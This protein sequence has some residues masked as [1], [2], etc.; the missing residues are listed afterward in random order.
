MLKPTLR[1]AIIGIG[2]GLAL[3]FVAAWLSGFTADIC[4]TDQVSHEHCISHNLA[5]FMLIQV[6]EAANAL[7]V[8]ITALATIAIASFTWTLWRSTYKLWLA[9]ERQIAISRQSAYAAETAASAAKKTA[10]TQIGAERAWFL[11]VIDEENFEKVLDSRINADGWPAVIRNPNPQVRFHFENFGKSPA[12]V[13]EICTDIKVL[14]NLPSKLTYTPNIPWNEEIVV[15]GGG[16][17]PDGKD[18]QGE[19]LLFRHILSGAVSLDAAN[20]VNNGDSYFWF[21]GRVVYDDIWGNEHV[22]RFCWGHDGRLSWFLP[23][24]G[25]QYNE[26]T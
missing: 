21:Y 5:A 13:K 9:S 19:W 22:T 6:Y 4:R 7:S 25:K 2:A 16:R 10:E 24:G 18:E 17:I 23:D 12:F 26:R 3:L 11:L 20:A 8:P 15:P 1:S 14:P